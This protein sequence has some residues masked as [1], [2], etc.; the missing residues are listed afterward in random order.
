MNAK[1]CTAHKRKC[2][3]VNRKSRLAKEPDRK[4]VKIS[5]PFKN[6]KLARASSDEPPIPR[7][8]RTRTRVLTK[9]I[10]DMLEPSEISEPSNIHEDNFS[11]DSN[12]SDDK[13]TNREGTANEAL[14]NFDSEDEEEVTGSKGQVSYLTSIIFLSCVTQGRDHAHCFS[15]FFQ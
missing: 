6:Q 1:Y 10:S 15:I 4:L 12:H 14:D 5:S 9:R 7:V 3:Q 2:L 11:S 8:G 13:V